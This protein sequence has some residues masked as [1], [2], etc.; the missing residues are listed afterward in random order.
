[1]IG[2][3]DRMARDLEIEQD[4]TFQRREWRVQRVAWVVLALLLLLGLVGAFGDGPLSRRT[5]R[6]PDGR[7][8]VRVQAMERHRSPSAIVLRVRPEDGKDT[9]QVWLNREFAEHQ[10]FETIHPEPESVTVGQDRLVY[11]FSVGGADDVVEIA[12]DSLPEGIGAKH[13]Q[14]GLVDGPSVAFGQFVF[15]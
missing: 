6:S 8:V 13:V 3:A 10:H 11:E 1:M 14:L 9:V 7:L 5:L 12:F 4:L 15:P 2:Y